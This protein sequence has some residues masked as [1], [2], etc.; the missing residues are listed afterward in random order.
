MVSSTS[1]RLAKVLPFMVVVLL[2]QARS[3]SAQDSVEQPLPRTVFAVAETTPIQ[4]QSFAPAST[5]PAPL[6]GLYASF[7]TL[8]A[9]DVASTRMALTAGGVEAN[10]LISRLAGSPVALTAVKAGVTG[11]MIYASERMWKKNR[12]AAVLTMIGLNAAYGV[13]VAHNYGVVARAKTL[14]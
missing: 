11:A 7:A 12:K 3:L 2:L 13:V 6:M 5:R 10:P 8:Q 4:G 9:L 1:R 14:E